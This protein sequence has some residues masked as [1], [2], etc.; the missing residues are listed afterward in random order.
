MPRYYYP[1]S[2][3]TVE[4]H[5]ELTMKFLKNKKYLDGGCFKYGTVTWSRNG[6]PIGNIRIQT[7]INQQSPFIRFIYKIRPHG[8]EEWTDMDYKYNLLS[9]PCRFGGKRWYFECGVYKNGVFCG[10]RVAKL[11]DAGNYFCCRQCAELSYES[12]NENKKY[13]KGFFKLLTQEDKAE[14]YYRKNVKRTHY[15]GKPTRKYRRYLSML[16]NYTEQ[17]MQIMLN[18]INRDLGG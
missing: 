9:I 15:R 6:E 3:D 18:Q 11:Y 5:K 8:A 14:E 13:R 4:E 17:D 7:D 1:G 10:R 12:C 16:D 2:R